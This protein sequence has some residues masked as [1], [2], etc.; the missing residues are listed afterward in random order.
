MTRNTPQELYFGSD[1]KSLYL[2][3][4]YID[5]F[6]CKYGLFHY[7]DPRNGSPAGY[8]AMSLCKPRQDR[9]V[10]TVAIM[11]CAEALLVGLPPDFCGLL[12]LLKIIKIESLFYRQNF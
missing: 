10:A 4:R 12:L 3:Y 5:E 6:T 7:T 8:F 11:T 9:K 2:I 1:L